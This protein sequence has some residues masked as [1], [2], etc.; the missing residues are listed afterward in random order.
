R[1]ISARHVT[2]FAAS[3]DFALASVRNHTAT[4]DGNEHRRCDTFVQKA[5]EALAED[6]AGL[7]N[8]GRAVSALQSLQTR[9]CLFDSQRNSWIRDGPLVKIAQ[10]TRIR[11]IRRRDQLEFGPKVAREAS[12]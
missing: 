9:A 12:G 5:V 11:K 7:S 10:L 8:S 1:Q 3:F 4:A 6:F 2:S